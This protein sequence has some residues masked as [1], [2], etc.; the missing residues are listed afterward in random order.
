MIKRLVKLL[1]LPSA[2]ETQRRREEAYLAKS[3]DLVDLERRQREL[4][5]KENSARYI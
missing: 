3:I 5:Y 1:R 4:L 2:H